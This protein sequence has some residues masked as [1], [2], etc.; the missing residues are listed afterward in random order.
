MP[1]GRRRGEDS[2]NEY[3]DSSSDGSSD[4]ELE[5]GLKYTREQRN[6]HHLSS[7]IPLRIDR[8]SLRDQHVALNEDFS[9]DEGE[10]VNSQGRLLFEYLERDLPYSREPLADK[11]SCLPLSSPLSSL[12]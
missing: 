6:H 4:C 9:S 3:R 8:L 2:D 12:N 5:R 10:S 11:V 7:E 1:C